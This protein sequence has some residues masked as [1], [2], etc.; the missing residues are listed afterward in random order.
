MRFVAQATPEMVHFV[1]K[2]MR[3]RDLEELLAICFE[4]DADQLADG[5]AGMY[6]NR[7]L[8][9]CFGYD[10]E[11]ICILSAICLRPNVWSVGMWATPDF[12]KIGKYLT[13][14]AIKY[15][16]PALQQAGAHRVECK[17]IVGYSE[18]HGWLRFIGFAEGEI[19]KMYGKN[20]EDFITF[21]W[22]EGMPIIKRP[23]NIR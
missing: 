14:F 6:G 8:S 10:N 5:L 1:S 19:E 16:F 9:F 21:Y 20:G 17:S 22:Y 23:R 2:N 11:P 18:I 3:P 7:P 12:P 13:Y 15:F 4:K